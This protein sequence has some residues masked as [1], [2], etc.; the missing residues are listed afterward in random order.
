MAPRIPGPGQ[1]YLGAWLS[2]AGRGPQPQ[3]E[4]KTLSSFNSNLGRPLSTVHIYQSWTGLTPSNQIRQVRANGAIP[5]VDWECGDSDA[6]IIAGADDPLI[7]TFATEL[8][9]L[10]TPI[11]LRWYY[12]PNFPGSPNYTNCIGADGPHGYQLAFQH[13]HNLFEA[14]GATNVAFVWAIGAAGPQDD[15]TSYYPGSAY[16]D[17]IGVDGYARTSTPGSA[18]VRNLFSRWY[19]QFSTFGKPMM[20][21]E[22][23]A[24]QGGQAQ[25]LQQLAAELPSEF[26]LIKGLVYFDAPGRH[27]ANTYPLDS[28]G[29]QEFEALSRTPYFQPER[30]ATTTTVSVSPASAQAGQGVELTAN[31]LSTDNGGSVSFI[32]NGEPVA[33]CDSVP[34]DGP[35]PSCTTTELPGGQDSITAVYSGDANYAGSSAPPVSAMMV[36]QAEAIGSAGASPRPAGTVLSMAPFLGI[37]TIAPVGPLQMPVKSGVQ[38]GSQSGVAESPHSAGLSQSVI[39]PLSAFLHNRGYGF[40][41]VMAGLAISAGLGAYMVTTW[42]SD[43]RNLRRKVRRG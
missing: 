33:G 3:T 14:A 2:P 43:R 38:V 10:K 8:A 21:T 18:M 39:E 11:F 29:M 27:V 31:I 13:I 12:E 32:V 15:L 9:S 37:P 7:S 17:W 19:T 35:T 24:Y 5:M 20:I 36:T 22:T 26:P 30:Q 28:T 42:A 41:V 40:A 34:V 1:A 16:V 6:N 4:L 23:G 25:Y